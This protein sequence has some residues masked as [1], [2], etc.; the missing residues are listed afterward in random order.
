MVYTAIAASGCEGG[1]L[2]AWLRS[3]QALWNQAGDTSSSTP[4]TSSEETLT[5]P[6]FGALTALVTTSTG[7]DWLPDVVNGTTGAVVGGVAVVVGWGTPGLEVVGA[8]V[9]AGGEGVPVGT[10]VELAEGLVL[11]D[12]L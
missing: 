2:I 8:A 3:A 6:S 4:L 11:E 7:V 10:A 5:L 1:V 12:I 9:A